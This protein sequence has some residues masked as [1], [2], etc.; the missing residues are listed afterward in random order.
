MSRVD[1]H[2]FTTSPKH[3]NLQIRLLALI[4][5]FEVTISFGEVPCYSLREKMIGE[6][7]IDRA[8]LEG[9]TSMYNNSVMWLH[10]PALPKHPELIDW[11][12]QLSVVCKIAN[13][14]NKPT[15][16]G[17]PFDLTLL[18]NYQFFVK[19]RELV[20][21]LDGCRVDKRK[22]WSPGHEPWNF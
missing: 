2:Q 16:G 19:G 8:E 7:K 10:S 11:I 22:N 17:K 3:E 18:T 14:L 13:S 1:P 9:C 12:N 15:E 4:A 6:I 5:D 21:A 20:T